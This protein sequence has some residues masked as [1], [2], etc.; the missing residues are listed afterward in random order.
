MPE[1]FGYAVSSADAH[2]VLNAVLASPINMIDTAASYGDGESERRIGQCFAAR[3]WDRAAIAGAAPR[4]RLTL[5]RG[6]ALPRRPLAERTRRPASAS[7]VSVA[8]SRTTRGL[9]RP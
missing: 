6:L 9:P 4:G 1:T 8:S 5:R 2:A 3:G 7:G